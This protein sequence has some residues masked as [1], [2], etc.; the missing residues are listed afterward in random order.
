[1]RKDDIAMHLEYQ[2]VI[3]EKL[4]IHCSTSAVDFELVEFCAGILWA[5]E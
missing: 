1:M 2:E 3:M 4:N 5:D